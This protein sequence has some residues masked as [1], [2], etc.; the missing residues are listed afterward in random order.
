MI[1]T[2]T[3][4]LTV[5]LC[6]IGVLKAQTYTKAG[7]VSDNQGNRYSLTAT[8]GDRVIWTVDGTTELAVDPGVSWPTKGKYDTVTKRL[9]ISLYNPHPDNCKYYNDSVE[10]VLRYIGNT[11]YFIRNGRGNF[12][13]FCAGSISG[14]NSITAAAVPGN[15]GASPRPGDDNGDNNGNMPPA[16]G[17]MGSTSSLPPHYVELPANGVDFNELL[18]VHDDNVTVSPNPATTKTQIYMSLDKPS[19]VDIR[20]YDIFGNLIRTLNTST[21]DQGSYSFGWDLTNNS[22]VIVQNGLYILVVK[23]A[24]STI[25]KRIMVTK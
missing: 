5:M 14:D 15:C 1:K 2:I 7:C 23:T 16:F 22:G 13:N 20:V 24:D 3:M 25:T 8:S 17:G 11:T 19:A 6:S 4:C 18:R 12:F 9:T 10:V 21:M